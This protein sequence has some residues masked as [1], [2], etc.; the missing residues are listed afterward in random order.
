MGT[1]FEERIEHADVFS[2][3]FAQLAIQFK[4]AP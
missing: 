4:A 2:F 3:L 1:A